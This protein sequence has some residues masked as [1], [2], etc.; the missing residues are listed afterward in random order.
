VTSAAPM[1]NPLTRANYWRT[2]PRARFAAP[3]TLRTPTSG[4]WCAP[5]TCTASVS[6][7]CYNNSRA[8]AKERDRCLLVIYL[9]LFI[10]NYHLHGYAMAQKSACRTSVSATLSA[11]TRPSTNLFAAPTTTRSPMKR[12]SSAGRSCSHTPVSS[13]ILFPLSLMCKVLRFFSHAKNIN[14]LLMRNFLGKDYSSS[15]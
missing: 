8:C 14:Y 7:L 15:N 2:L 6:D 4:T 11:L 3:T 9:L 10:T 13:H 1:R 5:P 12:L